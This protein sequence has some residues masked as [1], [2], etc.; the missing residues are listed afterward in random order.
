[1]EANHFDP[2]ED[3]SDPEAPKC[4]YWLVDKQKTLSFRHFANEISRHRK[5]IRLAG[6][7]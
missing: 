2:E 5:K 6:L 7:P 4:G 1:M 3:D